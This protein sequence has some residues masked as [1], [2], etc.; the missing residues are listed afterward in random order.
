MDFGNNEV[1]LCQLHKERDD[2]K[3]DKDIMELDL[4]DGKLGL[5]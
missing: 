1:H 5:I 2:L 4:I 3:T